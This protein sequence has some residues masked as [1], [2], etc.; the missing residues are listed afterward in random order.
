METLLDLIRTTKNEVRAAPLGVLRDSLFAPFVAF[1]LALHFVP[2]PLFSL[3]YPW[4]LV[5]LTLGGARILLR[6]WTVNA[7]EWEFY[8]RPIVREMRKAA[9]ERAR[10]KA[11]WLRMREEAKKEEARRERL[12]QLTR[13]DLANSAKDEEASK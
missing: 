3:D 12:W 4:A 1:S 2:D 7:A 9:E 8:C 5:V 11:H 10:E 13:T 6:L